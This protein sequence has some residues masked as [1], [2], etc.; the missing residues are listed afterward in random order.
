MSIDP[1]T[2]S[3]SWAPMLETLQ[4]ASQHFERWMA[5]GM[6]GDSLGRRVIND[7]K[8]MHVE[9]VAQSAL[10]S[11][12]PKL[13]GIIP[14]TDR[15]SPSI[16]AFRNWKYLEYRTRELKSPQQLLPLN[17]FHALEREITEHLAAITRRLDGEGVDSKVLQRST[18]LPG[19]VLPSSDEESSP[20]PHTDSEPHTTSAQGP[21]DNDTV[22]S[23]PVNSDPAYSNPAESSPVEKR[24]VST[25][26]KPNLL[27]L[28]LDP[29]SIQWL[30]GLGGA[31]MVIGLV[32]LLWI[33]EF[34]T[35]PVMAVGLGIV[36]IAVLAVGFCLIRWTRFQLAG[37]ALTLLSCL[38]MPLNLWYYSA[39]SLITLDGH[40]W[41]AAVVISAIYAASAWLLKDEMF[42]YVFTAGVAMTGLLMIAD[43]PPS[44]EKFWEIPFPATLLVVLGLIAIHVERAFTDQEGP[45]SRQRFG[46]AFF[47]SG[48]ALMGAGL[49]LVLAA[50]VSGDWLYEW[51]FRP[52]FEAWGATPSPICGPLRPLAFVLVAAATYAY[53]YSDLVVRRIGVYIH[54]A[55]VTLVWAELLAVQMLNLQLGMDAVIAVLAVTSL[56][57]HVV[58]TNAPIDNK[59]LRSLPSFGLVLG[60]LPVLLGGLVYFQHIG[61]RSIWTDAPASWSFVGAMVLAAGASR[62]GAHVHRLTSPNIT[63]TYFF[64]SGGA[65]I[66]AAATGLAALGGEH[67]EEHAPILML[68]PIGY[69]IAAKLYGERVQARPAL[70]VAHV[71]AAAMLASSLVSA[72]FGFTQAGQLTKLNLSLALFFGEAAVFYG[73]ASWMQKQPRWVYLS[74]LMTSAS[75]WQLMAVFGL[76]T[77][78]YILVFAILG[79]VLLTTYRLSFW[80]QTKAAPLAESLFQAGNTLLSLAF[81]SSIFHG[82]FTVLAD[83]FRG[84][85]Y[86]SSEHLDWSLAGFCALMLLISLGA[87]ALSRSIPWRRWYLLTTIAEG[88][89]ALLAVHQL[90]DL[91]PWQQIELFAVLVGG[92]LLAIGH[93]GWYR[94]EDRH[95]DTVSTSLFVGAA[96]TSG[97]LAMATWYDRYH[98]QFLVVNEFGFLFVSVL[99]LASGLVFKLKSTTLV[100]GL[101]T[102]L[103]FVTLLILV[104]WSQLN[105][106]ALAIT[107]GGGVIFGFGLTLAFFRDRILELPTHIKQRE[108][109]FRVLN[110]R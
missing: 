52:V 34:F 69:L 49:L 32:I 83:N 54:L 23:D 12:S 91:N 41:V 36:N 37:K 24:T 38:V 97:P 74:T 2:P 9:L 94:E 7:L 20:Q 48:H 96:L 93:V 109:I 63:L 106:V 5:A 92:V 30:L 90:I 27:E 71:A 57:I 58:Q 99:L 84:G 59:Y 15:E 6:I 79:L 51:W 62:V 100:G 89:I 29:R 61:L 50:Q 105:S 72:A 64:A 26:L 76:Q 47:W 110:W 60:L 95:N 102:G 40:L 81:F 8:A 22:N 108:G 13:V 75:L 43:L 98:S 44:P 68:I 4:F 18:V 86:S 70:W 16:Q 101:M 85:R 39:N 88:A 82:L 19:I 87:M 28:L 55:A 65:L 33:N 11:E 14:A 80:E 17:D 45:F 3:N 10:L 77:Q 67:W 25:S 31:L 66:V 1:P 56:V 103:Y 35:P 104:P 78:T 46:L 53:V 107:V 21:V 73:L 42:V